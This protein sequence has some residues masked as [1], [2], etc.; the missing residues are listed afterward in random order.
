MRTQ[1]L[2]V[3]VQ[4]EVAER[5]SSQGCVRV[6]CAVV[7]DRLEPKPGTGNQ[8]LHARAEETAVGRDPLRARGPV[9]G[10]VLERTERED[11]VVRLTRAMVVPVLQPDVGPGARM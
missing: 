9:P 11:R 10:K 4:H 6:R 7:S 3:E 2:R 8:P 5:L 1:G